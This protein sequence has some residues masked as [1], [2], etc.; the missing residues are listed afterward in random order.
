[1]D[2]EPIYS[3]ES[4]DIVAVSSARRTLPVEQ[5]PKLLPRRGDTPENVRALLERP[6]VISRLP[7]GRLRWTYCYRSS[8]SRPEGT[9]TRLFRHTDWHSWS[10]LVTFDTRGRVADVASNYTRLRVFEG[11]LGSLRKP[12]LERMTADQFVA[13]SRARRG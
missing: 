11:L 2:T 7:D 8:R 10:I 12:A 13:L 5:I 9:M 6:D 3:E 1:M 4:F